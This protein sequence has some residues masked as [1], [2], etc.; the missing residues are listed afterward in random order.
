[1]RVNKLFLLFRDD[2]GFK[3]SQLWYDEIEF[4]DFEKGCKKKGFGQEK[5]I[6]TRKRDSNK[7]KLDISRPW[8][9]PCAQKLVSDALDQ[10]MGIVCK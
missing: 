3:A 1:M 2:D 5:G 8:S 7:K 4:W 6:R 10:K 9:G